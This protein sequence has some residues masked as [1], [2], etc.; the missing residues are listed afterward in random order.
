MRDIRFRQPL[1]RK[2]KFDSWHYWGFLSDGNFSSPSN[3]WV[4][5]NKEYPSQQFTGLKDKNGKEIYEGDILKWK[6]KKGRVFEGVD[7]PLAPLLGVKPGEISEDTICTDFVEFHDGC[8]FLMCPDTG[9][10]AFL[11]RENENAEI[12]GNIHSNPE[13]LNRH[14]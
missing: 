1:I 2:G 10:G 7:D 9:G 3:D 13:L 4:S 14:C 5:Q 11:N 8:F 6:L 12:I